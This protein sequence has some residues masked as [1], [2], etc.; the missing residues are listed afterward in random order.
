MTSLNQDKPFRLERERT[1][2]EINKSV[3][4][5]AKIY[6]DNSAIIVCYIHGLGGKP[7]AFY[8][9]ILNEQKV[10]LLWYG[11]SRPNSFLKRMLV[12]YLLKFLPSY[13]GIIRVRN[14][15]E[16]ISLFPLIAEQS[17]AGIYMFDLSREDEILKTINKN[18][19][20]LPDFAD[21]DP[22]HFIYLVD[23]DSIS[24]QNEGIIEILKYGNQCPLSLTSI[25][26]T[27]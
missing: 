9:S 4:E 14:G 17:M 27:R 10:D 8:K 24:V 1:E 22:T 2:E 19:N 5:L 3:L 20:E 6:Q 12:M 15:D 21:V 13:G 7:L 23:E 26:G 11:I 25:V 16:I 18:P